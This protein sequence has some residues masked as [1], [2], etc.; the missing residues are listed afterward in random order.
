MRGW[1]FCAG[2]TRET[3]GGAIFFGVCDDFGVIKGMRINSSPDAGIRA[4]QK[5]QRQARQH[6]RDLRHLLQ[7]NAF[8]GHYQM[9]SHWR[10]T[11]IRK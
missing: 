11:C 6:L 2:R 5:S 8:I 1:L 7:R 9:D 3:G 10:G 4:G